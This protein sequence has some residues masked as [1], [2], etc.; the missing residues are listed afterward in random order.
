MGANNAKPGSQQGSSNLTIGTYELKTNEESR[1][2]VGSFG[3]VY[4]GINI[5]TGFPVAIKAID[6]IKAIR[7]NMTRDAIWK[8]VAIMQSILHENIVCLLNGYENDATLY[9]V[10]EYCNGGDLAGYIDRKGKQSESTLR[11]FIQQ[12]RR[13]MKELHD[14]DIVHRDLKPQNILLSVDARKSTDVYSCRPQEIVLKIADFG[15]SRVLQSGIYA[16]TVCGTFSYMAPEVVT[17]KYDVKADIYSI[18]I[19]LYECLTGEIPFPSD[20]KVDF[21]RETSSEFEEFIRSLIQRKVKK[22]ADFKNFMNHPGGRLT[23]QQMMADRENNVMIA[24]LAEQAKRYDGEL[25][26]SSDV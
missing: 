22:R 2:G 19:I 11:I 14:R 23:R 21:P 13:A 17:R 25:C 5:E 9:I 7:I 16:S 18:G 3:T 26:L 4:R 8:E 24:K 1:L 10:M 15:L 12:I 20:N 6:K